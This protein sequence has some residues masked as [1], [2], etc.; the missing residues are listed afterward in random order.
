M[1]IIHT[2]PDLVPL[3]ENMPCPTSNMR[4]YP[5]HAALLQELYSRGVYLID[6]FGINYRSDAT[7]KFP[8]TALD[9]STI[10][11]PV[12]QAI[13]RSSN[14]ALCIWAC[15]NRLII[16][17]ISPPNSADFAPKEFEKVKAVVEWAENFAETTGAT[18]MREYSKIGLPEIG[19]TLDKAKLPRGIF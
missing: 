16:Y 13:D 9:E 18:V 19:W 14:G 6:N 15:T 10:L 4:D 8:A 17:T 5:E 12:C 7:V 11:T 2:Y 3:R 1:C